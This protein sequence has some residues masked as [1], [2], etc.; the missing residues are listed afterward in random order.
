M[1]KTEFQKAKA[2]WARGR[3]FEK[4]CELVF[5]VSVPA[6]EADRILLATSGIYRLW[7]NGEF[8]G[9]GPAR[10]AHGFF[11]VDEYELDSREGETVV[12]VEVLGYCVNSYDTLYQRSFLTAEIR[13]ETGVSAYTGDGRFRIYDFRQRVQKVQRYSFQRA[14]IDVYRLKKD[15][16]IFD[17]EGKK[18]EEKELEPFAEQAEKEPELFRERAEKEPELFQERVT[19]EPEFFAESPKE[20]VYIA[21]EARY[22]QFEVLQAEALVSEGKA[23]F[24]KETGQVIPEQAYFQISDKLLGFP[25]E[26]E[27]AHIS[28]EA[29]RIVFQPR[30]KSG[31][32]AFPKHLETEYV[33]YRFPYNATGF[34]RIAV[35]AKTA[36]RV[37]V[38]FDEILTGEDIDFL[39][40]YSCNCFVYDLE[41]GR[42]QLMSFGPYTMK[43]IK[44]TVKG[45]CTLEKV[46]L[47]EYKHP[48]PIRQVCLPGEDTKLQLIYEA[49]LE[50]FRAN[51]VDVFTDCPSRERGG[52]LCDSYFTSGVERVL[53]GESVLERAFLENFILP[54]RFSHLPEGMLPMCYPGDHNNGNFIPN[55][56]M[57]FVLE[58]EKYVENTGDRKLAEQAKD[59]VFRLLSYFREYENELGL[60]EDLGGWVFL[61][62]SRANDP[63]LVK[64]V[65]FPTNMLYARMLLAVGKLY[66]NT[67]NI[68]KAKK[69]CET[70]RKRSV[71]GV[72]F[73]DQ[74]HRGRSGW[75]NTGES[76]EAC[77]YYAFF[78]GIATKEEDG[79][80]WEILVKE[81]GP[82]RRERG[83][84]PEI[85]G[86]N[87]FI[88]NYLRVEL[89]YES[90]L[91][92]AV[93]QNIKDY[94][95]P[96]AEKTGTLWEHEKPTG[97]CNHG[98]ASYVIY[99][100]AGIYGVS[101]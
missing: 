56:A 88:G 32:M 49:A 4:N 37:F 80:L 78:T 42:Y 67:E 61:E 62:W 3:G 41:P 48:G 94:F 81:F 31:P 17:A 69:L 95:L 28:E 44:I 99:W 25:Y 47:V 96:M 45:V 57:W 92:E 27:E 98:F 46:E 9:A 79:R 77:Q 97:S 82:Q 59:R 86:A 100:L 13:G 68:Q 101:S 26:E 38:Q 64:G 39:R 58:L 43:Y 53:T 22:P 2:I 35:T 65:N 54:D 74:E 7:I 11:R 18:R 1:K 5:A 14:F 90:G 52:W 51:A 83:L 33:L 71:R 63:D 24:G 21:R 91:Y 8:R 34:Y 66:E 85:A 10:T 50:S 6:A 29:Q 30:T 23:S 36:G 16:G 20:P 12:A 73:T 84:Y 70:I 93:L 72:F 60:L 87:A 75:E 40:M 15:R 19:E 55:W 89:L 76:T